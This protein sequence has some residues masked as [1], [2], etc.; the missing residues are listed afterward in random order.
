MVEI[1]GK[2]PPFKLHDATGSIVTLAALKG[3]IVV[4]YFYPQDDTETCTLQAQGFSCLA[5]EFA[6]AGCTVI[7]VSPDGQ[8]SHQKF[9]AKYDLDIVLLADEQKSAIEAYGVWIEKQMFGRRHMGVERA[10]FLIDRKGKIARIWHKV[11]VRSHA[12]QVLEAVRSL[13][14]DKPVSR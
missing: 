8:N 3:Q 1:G 13:S 2:A 14:G 7:G 6:S 12:A 9:K 10:T 4:L 5:A 11:R